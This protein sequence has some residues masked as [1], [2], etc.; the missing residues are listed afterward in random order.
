MDALHVDVTFVRHDYF[1]VL[2]MRMAAGRQFAPEEDREPGGTPVVILGYGLATAFFGSP[3]RAPGRPVL[4]NGLDFTVVGVAPPE[5]RGLKND[6]YSQMWLPGTSAYARHVPGDRWDRDRA[7]GFF[8]AFVGRLAAT[9]DLQ[10]A[11]AELTAATRAL[12]DA[13]PAANRHFQTAEI[14]MERQPGM[15]FSGGNTR[16]RVAFMVTMFASAGALLLLLAWANVGNLL[17]FRG[18]RRREEMALRSALG[19][20][21]WRLLRTH[22]IEVSLISLAGGAVGLVLTF[23]LARL[24]E[25]AIVPDAGFLTLP[26]DWRVGGLMLSAS[27]LVGLFFGGAPAVF[28]SSGVGLALAVQRVGNRR[29]RR[30]RHSLTVLQ[31]AISLS[32]L[33]GAMLQS[34]PTA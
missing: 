11:G 30:L 20:S 10:R 17:L 3:E 12:A 23:G 8:E 13:Y 5:F 4:V 33:V 34:A 26:I 16:N 14:R 28:G 9:V 29:G 7:G 19:A 21:R 6:H 15:S 25:G 31:L 1:Q 27:V 18:A 22:L 2:G 32:L 24:F